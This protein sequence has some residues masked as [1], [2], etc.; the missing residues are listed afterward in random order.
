MDLPP[1]KAYPQLRPMDSAVDTDVVTVEAG[2]ASL[3]AARRLVE[4]GV[5]AVPR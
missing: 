1:G 3:M 5:S 2:L 4:A